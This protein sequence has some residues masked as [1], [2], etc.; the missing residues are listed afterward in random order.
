MAA[1]F[2]YKIGGRYTTKPTETLHELSCPDGLCAQNSNG[3]VQKLT[4]ILAGVR[5]VSPQYENQITLKTELQI[6]EFSQPQ[7]I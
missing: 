3:T 6:Y 2:F 7:I 1:T 5:L 4:V